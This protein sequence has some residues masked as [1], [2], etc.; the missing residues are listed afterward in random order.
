MPTGSGRRCSSARARTGASVRPAVMARTACGALRADDIP[1]RTAWAGGT[2]TLGAAMSNSP[3]SLDRA[4]M[5]RYGYAVVDMLVERAHEA[6][7]PA[8]VR[9]SRAEMERR[10]R[11]PPP[12]AGQPFEELLGKLGEDVLPFAIR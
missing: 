4:T 12:A 6:D 11:E 8:I 3:L 7:A 9:A 1:R 2:A 5:Q 10:L